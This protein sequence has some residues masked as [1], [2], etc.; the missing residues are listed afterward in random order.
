MVEAHDTH[1]NLE[2]YVH[3]TCTITGTFTVYRLSVFMYVCIYVC[4]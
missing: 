2:C 1:V 3:K 4:I